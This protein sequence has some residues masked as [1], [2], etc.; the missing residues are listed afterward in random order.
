MCGADLAESLILTGPLLQT[1]STSSL[2][3]VALPEQ[4]GKESM[5]DILPH[6]EAVDGFLL[7]HHLDNLAVQVDKEGSPEATSNT[8]KE[9]RTRV[10]GRPFLWRPSVPHPPGSF[11]PDDS[12]GRELLEVKGEVESEPSFEESSDGF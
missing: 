6:E 1:L 2:P 5:A 12:K 4:P 7:P 10:E 9:R 3:R 8:G 11:L